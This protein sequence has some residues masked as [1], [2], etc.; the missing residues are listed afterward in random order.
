MVLP[1]STLFAQGAGVDLSYGRWW[2]GDAP[3]FA[4]TLS[5]YQRVFGP[6]DY[7]LGVSHLDDRHPV[8]DRT[9]TGGVVSLAVNRR[10]PGPYAVGAWGLGLRHADRDP[11]AYWAVGAGYSV[12]LVGFLSL[13]LEALYRA[14]DRHLGG[15]W[16]L[17]KDDHKGLV[18]QGRLAVG[19]GNGRGGRPA[20]RP[21]RRP[22]SPERGASVATAEEASDDVDALSWA[23]VQTALEAMGAPYRWGGTDAN[24][25]DCSGLIQYAYGEHGIVLPRSSRDQARVGDLVELDVRV[26]VPGDV[27]GFRVS[28]G[29]VSHV[30]LYVG[31]GE[32][33]HSTAAGVKLSSLTAADPDSRW[34]RQRWVSARRILD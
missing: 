26:L 20:A 13:G 28:G 14:E 8:D 27:L 30:G 9:Q 34:W 16:Q 22:L 11:D 4:Y 5:Y 21:E 31:G 10:G 17:D 24:G 23:V 1:G 32:F 15:F 7:G 2:Y 25:Y 29:G 19:F 6:L 12:R 18:L 3:A 33:I